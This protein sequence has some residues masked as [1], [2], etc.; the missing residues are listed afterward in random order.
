[1]H[2][3]CVSSGRFK[4]LAN[5]QSV[6]G[7]TLSTSTQVQLELREDPLNKNA[8]ST[9]ILAYQ[10]F[11]LE[12]LSSKHMHGGKLATCERSE[13]KQTKQAIW[14]IWASFER[15]QADAQTAV[16]GLLLSHVEVRKTHSQVNIDAS[17]DSKEASTYSREQLPQLILN[18]PLSR[19]DS[20]F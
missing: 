19:K 5:N 11:V 17:S 15:Q 16:Q 10:V 3:I 8:C 2:Y 7:V 18:L 9:E 20:G 14:A 13:N 1:M 6:R 4:V 12:I